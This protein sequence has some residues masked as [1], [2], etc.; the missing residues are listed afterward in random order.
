MKNVINIKILLGIP[1]SGK[2]E[3]SKKYISNNRNVVRINRDDM[4]NMFFNGVIT[5]GNENFVNKMKKN[6]II[7]A[8]KLDKNLLIDDTHCYEKTL[9]DLISFIQKYSK[10]LNK[11]I[12]IEL[13][14]FNT[15]INICIDRNN[16]RNSKISKN[17]IFFMFKEKSKIDISKLNI[18][19]YIKI[20]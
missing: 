9:T 10:L 16:K 8:L 12:F 1:G 19:N 20:N 5:K 11:Q 7:N 3:Y 18:N 2:T 13:I 17:V 14:D 15:D 6:I 4:F